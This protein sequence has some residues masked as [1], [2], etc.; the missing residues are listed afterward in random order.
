[1]IEQF[2]GNE[3]LNNQQLTLDFVGLSDE[4][5]MKGS[6]LLGGSGTK[7]VSL[8]DE[9]DSSQIKTVV[10]EWG[11]LDDSLLIL[12]DDCERYKESLTMP[13]ISTII[14]NTVWR[15]TP[16]P[17]SFNLRTAF[18]SEDY[19]IIIPP[20]K[21]ESV[22]VIKDYLKRSSPRPELLGELYERWV[23]FG[24]GTNIR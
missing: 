6:A 12:L 24:I 4:E 1:M 8:N 3:G 9:F 15:L 10:F 18:P 16:Q 14:D 21:G 23:A 5:K 19:Y 17:K 22:N 7:F 2:L 20:Y 13:H 11:V